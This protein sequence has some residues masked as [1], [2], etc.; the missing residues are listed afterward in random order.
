[1]KIL[2]ILT[3]FSTLFSADAL[4]VKDYPKVFSQLGTP[5]F[6]QSDN[7][8]ALRKTGLFKMHEQSI[9][10]YLRRVNIAIGHGHDA[11][12]SK[13]DQKTRAYLKELRSIQKLHDAIEKS[14][15]KQL[16]RSIHDDNQSSFYTLSSVP[17][18]F[19]RTDTRLKEKAA[20]YYQQSKQAYTASLKKQ[21]LPQPDLSYLETLAKESALDQKSYTYVQTMFQTQQKN[22]QVEEKNTL[23]TFTPAYRSKKPIRIISI[24]TA[25]GFD[26]YLENHAFYDVSIELKAVKLVN[27]LS[28]KAL[29]FTGSFQAQSRTK[30]LHFS[31]Q[32]PQKESQFQTLYNTTIGRVNPS[33]DKTYLYALPYA[34]AQSY[35]L[36]QGFNGKHTHTGQSAYA[37]D[38][39]MNEGTK[40]HAMRGGTVVAVESK[41]TE[42]GNSPAFISKSNY[43]MIQHDDGTMAMYAHLKPNGVHVKLGQ[44]VYKH[45]F[46]A[47]SGNTGYSSGPHLHVHISAIQDLKTGSSSVPFSFLSQEGKVD[48]PQEGSYYISK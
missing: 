10:D 20:A 2:L 4:T 5:L 29:P 39:K 28:S 16:Y 45:S 23:N 9:Q 35:Q 11:D 36:T 32:D 3:L 41:Q 19:V 15:K 21:K 47:L 27:M 43:I 1:M 6:N 8:K 14:Y 17:L 30:I 31:I 22:Q 33:Y 7:F 42:H 37:L 48:S 18:A 34:R 40:V 13:D 44:K 24:K 12:N 38:F 46:I 25:D 26:L